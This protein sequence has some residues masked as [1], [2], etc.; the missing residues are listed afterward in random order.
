MQ[1]PQE[2]PSRNTLFRR[3]NRL[4]GAI[5]GINTFFIFLDTSLLL[6]FRVKSSKRPLF[7]QILSWSSMVMTGN[8]SIA[9]QHLSVLTQPNKLHHR[10][11]RILIR[12]I[13]KYHHLHRLTA[14]FFRL[15]VF[16]HDAVVLFAREA[17][18]NKKRP[19]IEIL[20]QSLE[21]SPRRV[22]DER[23]DGRTVDRGR[24][25]RRTMAAE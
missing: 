23:S 18:V 21:A 10:V 5:S 20:F 17:N 15:F 24:S 19:E 1:S 9:N 6:Y 12:L 13:V 11:K 3:Q 2:Q 8:K 4:Y 16:H 25:C 22:K 14:T 7:H